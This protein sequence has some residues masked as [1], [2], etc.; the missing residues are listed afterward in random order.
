[1]KT[2]EI[3]LSLKKRIDA[4][5][6]ELRGEKIRTGDHRQRADKA[7]EELHQFR[8]DRRSEN[9]KTEDDF[10]AERRA[11]EN[12]ETAY[13]NHRSAVLH[14]FMAAS[15]PETAKDVQRIVELQ[16]AIIGMCPT[17]RL[18]GKKEPWEM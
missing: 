18:E 16:G 2:K 11:R 9:K 13:D 14:Y 10:T 6:C 3:I 4:L 8:V 17:R 5:E 15:N 1:M 7:Q 12:A